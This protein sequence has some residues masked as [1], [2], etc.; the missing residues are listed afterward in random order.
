MAFIHTRTL[1]KPWTKLN[2]VPLHLA[3]LL[4][5][6]QK[7]SIGLV[8]MCGTPTWCIRG[9]MKS[10]GLARRALELRTVQAQICAWHQASHP[11]ARSGKL[12]HA[13]ASAWMAQHPTMALI[14]SLRRDRRYSCSESVEI[15]QL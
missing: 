10:T 2:I 12:V 1:Q 14:Y 4:W 11:F 15:P 6:W 7:T 3:K 5:N 13:S 9:Q 8:P